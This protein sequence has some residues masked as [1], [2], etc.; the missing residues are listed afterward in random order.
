VDDPVFSSD[1]KRVASRG[2]RGKKVVVVADGRES[3]AWD[4]IMEKQPVF[5]P[6]GKRLAYCA[7]R[8]GKWRVVVD[9]REGKL[10]DAVRDVV[11]SPDS[12]H[13]AYIASDQTGD[14][15]VV[16]G[17][18]GQRYDGILAASRPAFGTDSPN[19]VRFI[20]FRGRN[21]LQ[22]T[23]EIQ[24]GTGAAAELGPQV[25]G[26][27][28]E[29]V[30]PV[31][32]S[33]AAALPA[34][35]PAQEEAKRPPLAS[36]PERSSRGKRY[37]ALAGDYKGIYS[38][39]ELGPLAVRV[40]EDGRFSGVVQSRSAGRFSIGAMLEGDGRLSAQAQAG[41]FT[42]VF[43]GRFGRERNTTVG[44][45]TWRSN[46]GFR[47]KWRVERGVL[48]PDT[49]EYLDQ[50]SAV[51]AKEG[52]SDRSGQGQDS[53]AQ[54]K[55]QGYAPPGPSDSGETSRV[56][57]KPGPSS[58]GDRLPGH[59]AQGVAEKSP[60][61]PAPTAPAIPQPSRAVGKLRETVLVRDA[62]LAQYFQTNAAL[63]LALAEERA[64][65]YIC[66][67]G[68]TETGIVGGPALT[69]TADA[70]HVLEV[71]RVISRTVKDLII[72]RSYDSE[73]RESARASHGDIK[74]TGHRDYVVIDGKRVGEAEE[75]A[76]LTWCGVSR[77]PAFIL[78]NG[79]EHKAVVADRTVDTGGPFSELQAS[80]D[81]SRHAY[82][83]RSGGTWE[84]VLSG[85]SLGRFERIRHVRLTASGEHVAYAA[86]QGGSEAVMW[87]G[88]ALSEAGEIADIEV[89]GET[90]DDV[91]WVAKRSD[92]W[93]I[94]SLAARSGPVDEVF[95]GI[96]RT[97]QVAP[98]GH[99]AAVVRRGEQVSIAADGQVL[100]NIPAEAGTEA[101]G[102]FASY[103]P[104]IRG[105]AY[106]KHEEDGWHVVAGSRTWGPFPQS[107][108]S[109][110]ISPSGAAMAGCTVTKVFVGTSQVASDLIVFPHTLR[111]ASENTVKFAGLKIDRPPSICSWSCVVEGRQG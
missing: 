93:Y 21:L 67:L 57:T 59:E 73:G 20:A 75:V 34:A 66:A 6:D 86:K 96:G 49:A 38:G 31:P 24:G 42:V 101:F 44:S 80:S 5:S 61:G 85:R 69:V 12:Q 74:E 90:R 88:T 1:G 58:L 56:T 65:S 22:A 104:G 76:F 4:G 71:Q 10:Y 84:M 78:R 29:A 32:Q 13:V 11:F 79:N 100:C 87:D 72:T 15:L 8:D 82:A 26:R 23:A 103:C 62:E 83:R 70:S 109:I 40:E 89:T 47:G 50:L 111:F 60:T 36:E 46:T 19:T 95:G 51:T 108:A 68:A 17:Q 97:L 110:A 45:G 63:K 102:G 91:V 37:E 2:W 41:P 7:L 18:E 43:E 106:Q 16:N 77:K 3:R 105:F 25:A 33:T 39:A 48:D 9:G 52:A 14:W 98:G 54:G 30:S 27:G 81:G 64:S 92:G 99:W 107:L 94:E 55:G 28:T 53:A 35:T